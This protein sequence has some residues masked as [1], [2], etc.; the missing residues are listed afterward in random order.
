MLAKEA[1][2]LSQDDVPIGVRITAKAD[3][4]SWPDSLFR[5]IMG[6]RMPKS[7]HNETRDDAVDVHQLRAGHWSRSQFYLHRIG[8]HPSRR[9]P[10]SCAATSGAR[11]HAAWSAARARTRRSTCCWSIPAWRAPISASSAASTRMR[12][13]LETTGPWATVSGADPRSAATTITTGAGWGRW[14]SWS[15]CADECWSVHFCLAGGQKFLCPCGG[16]RGGALGPQC[17]GPA[18]G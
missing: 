9:A 6:T 11:R 1:S 16:M 18:P 3:R 8:R 2:S 13:S 10:T 15:W 17:K 7:V 14:A 5:R 4:E 12:R